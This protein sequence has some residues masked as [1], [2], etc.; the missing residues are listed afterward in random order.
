MYLA[1]VAE[2]LC[3]RPQLLMLR[4]PQCLLQVAEIVR[5][6]GL[7]RQPQPVNGLGYTP[8]LGKDGCMTALPAKIS[9]LGGAA[10]P[11]E[12]RCCISGGLPPV[13]VVLT[14]EMH[15]ARMPARG[16]EPEPGACRGTIFRHA[17]A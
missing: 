14:E 6:R 10:V 8:L 16:G 11:L 12:R 17:A 15:G 2:L 7:D 5:R 9:A 4:L 1:C 3:Q 13:L